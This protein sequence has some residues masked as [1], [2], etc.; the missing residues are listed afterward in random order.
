[1][2]KYSVALLVRP[3][4]DAD[5][6][7]GDALPELELPPRFLMR[8]IARPIVLLLHRANAIALS[9]MVIVRSSGARSS[10]RGSGVA[11][12]MADVR[13]S[14]RT[15]VRTHVRSAVSRPSSTS[16][17]RRWEVEA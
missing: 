5:P 10:G 13:P 6:F 15:Y 8:P 9:I 2:H 12:R 1:M 14:V 16:A 4:A 7:L 11:G 17:E 3:L